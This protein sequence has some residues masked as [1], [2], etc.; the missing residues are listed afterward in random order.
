MRSEAEPEVEQLL[1]AARAGKGE[2]LG[3]ALERYR[4]YLTLLARLRIGRQLQ[5]K[6]DAADLVQETFLEAHRSF[7]RFRG[8]SARTFA[9]WLRR[10]LAGN[11]AHLVRR[12][13]SQG[14]NINLEQELEQELDASSELLEKGLAAVQPSPSEGAARREQAVIL[15]D[16]LE[17]LPPDYR[18]VIVLRQIESLSFAEVARRLGRSEDSVQKLWIRG[19]DALRRILDDPT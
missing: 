3:T 6:V 13:C 15:A 12:Y 18:D 17:R 8:N 2:A 7:R 11:L 16:A 4:N 9:A 10:I 19:L 1:E 5:G 14:R